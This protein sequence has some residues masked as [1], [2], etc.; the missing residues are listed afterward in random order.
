MKRAFFALAVFALAVGIATSAQ[1]FDVDRMV[2]VLDFE[3]GAGVD[4]SLSRPLAS[5]AMAAI[6]QSGA[7][8]VIDR[9]RMDRVLEEQ[10][11]QLSDCTSTDCRV[12]MGQMLGVGRIVVGDARRIG[13]TVVLDLQVIRVE[14]GQVATHVGPEKSYCGGAALL[15]VVKAMALRAVGETAEMPA[16]TRAAG[17]PRFVAGESSTGP[18]QTRVEEVKP[19]GRVAASSGPAGLFITTKPEGASVYL[20]DVKAGSTSPA[21]QKTNLE[22]GGRIRVR[23][24]KDLYH[25]KVFDVDLAPGVT[26]YEGVA[27]SPR[28]RYAVD[29]DRAGRGRRVHRRGSRGH[30]AVHEQRDAFGPAPGIGPQ[31]ALRAGGE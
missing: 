9:S 16:C 24:E 21:F 19:T 26:K 3:I 27:L 10:A 1:V 17:G 4:A 11:I 28:V 2:A 30:D 20:G 13:D 6:Q 5:A 18:T 8:T 23:L 29:H 25:P 15:D 14:T 22:A 31:G 7:Y 12:Q